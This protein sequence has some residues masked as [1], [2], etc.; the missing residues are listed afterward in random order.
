MS[1]MV[2]RVVGRCSGYSYSL[3][4]AAAVGGNDQIVGFDVDRCWG[5]EVT[6]SVVV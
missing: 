4:V 1:E 2:E 6:C 3:Q 5:D